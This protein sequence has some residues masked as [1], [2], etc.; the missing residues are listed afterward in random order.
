ML[1]LIATSVVAA[2]PTT[3]LTDADRW[4]ETGREL[5]KQKRYLEA[6]VAFDRSYK[7]DP[8]IGTTL[9]LAD[10]HE[11]LG[12]FER[13]LLLF[14]EAAAKSAETNDEVRTSFARKRAAAVAKRLATIVIEVTQ[15]APPDL[16]ISI[17][18]RSVPIA[19]TIR[20]RVDPAAVEIVAT[21]GG[22]P[23]FRTT[24]TATS[25]AT[26]NVVIPAFD[27]PPAATRPRR[28]RARVRLAL[29]VAGVGVASGIAAT[30]LTFKARGDYTSA[31]DGPGCMTVPNGVVCDAAGERGIASA[32]RLADVGTGLAVGC[33]VLLA[34]SAALYLTAPR[35]TL[36]VS[37][38]ASGG[39][40]G[41]SISGSF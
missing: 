15:P 10:C 28:Q 18:G 26:V 25:G 6:C 36:V 22:K 7:I 14:E 31:V 41:V 32:Q 4:F 30:A 3:D 34:T 38:T 35:E 16:A 13:A 1:L 27:D 19:A 37:P 12:H 2:Q 33:G 9:N 39:S 21:A 40:F 24:V 5:A 20:E 11:Q 8:S 29:G 17:A 23:P